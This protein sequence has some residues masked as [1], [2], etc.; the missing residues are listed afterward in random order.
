MFSTVNTTA[1]SLALALGL[2]CAVAFSDPAPGLSAPMR[3]A[4]VGNP[5]THRRAGAGCRKGG[6]DCMLS[7]RNEFRARVTSEVRLSV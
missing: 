5:G 2:I 7:W 1:V 4:G 3:A 6:V